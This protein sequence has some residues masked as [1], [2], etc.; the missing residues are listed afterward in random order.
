LTKVRKQPNGGAMADVAAYSYDALG[1]RFQ[2]SAGGTT[3]T[4]YQ[5]GLT[6]IVEKVGGTTKN[7]RSVPGALGNVI[8]TDD[9][10]G[11]VY[12]AYD[13]L[14][15]VLAAFN[16]NGE[17]VAEPVLDAFG[18]L[19]GGSHANFGLT[20]KQFDSDI[21]LYY[22]NA[23][24]Y[25]PDTGRFV[26]ADPADFQRVREENLYSITD[27]VNLVDPTGLFVVGPSC[28]FGCGL[29]GP[30]GPMKCE[31]AADKI[32]KATKKVKDCMMKICNSIKQG[33]PSDPWDTT[34]MCS[35]EEDKD[36]NCNGNEG[37]KMPGSINIHLCMGHFSDLWGVVAHE[38][39]HVCGGIG[40]PN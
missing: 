20:T 35:Y 25:D 31:N 13:R 37:Y 3:T 21:G 15:N 39:Y 19:N 33:S 17:K 38:L 24:W 4:Y 11:T 18:W 29:R 8:E 10:A 1:R 27:P 36:P 26:S 23:R 9:G 5:D 34:I 12:Y 16:A 14:G 22:F 6:P 40:E 32:T 30:K 7:H 28:K 2:K